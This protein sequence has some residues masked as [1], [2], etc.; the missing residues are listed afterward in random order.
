VTIGDVTFD[1]EPTGGFD[2]DYLPARRGADDRLDGSSR[3]RAHERLAAKRARK[4]PS[5]EDES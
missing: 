4:R 3:T 1:F 2:A 5:D